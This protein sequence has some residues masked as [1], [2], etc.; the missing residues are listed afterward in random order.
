[1]HLTNSIAGSYLVVNESRRVITAHNENRLLAPL[2]F[3]RLPMHYYRIRQE[4]VSLH[5][6]GFAPR[7]PSLALSCSFCAVIPGIS[8]PSS[9]VAGVLRL[10]SKVSAFISSEII[11]VRYVCC[12]FQCT[13]H[14]NC[15]LRG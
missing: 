12:L 2:R 15:H 10:I 3:F 13:P 7:L 6:G 1:M 9:N 4:Q 11:S 14:H 5:T 8:N